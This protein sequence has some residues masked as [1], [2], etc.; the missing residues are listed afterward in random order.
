MRTFI[1]MDWSEIEK[2]IYIGEGGSE[3]KEKWRDK[4]RSK[5][6][7]TVQVEYLIRQSLIVMNGVKLM[8]VIIGICELFSDLSKKN[9]I[10]KHENEKENWTWLNVINE[11]WIWLIAIQVKLW[12][13]E[14]SQEVWGKKDLNS[15]MRARLARYPPCQ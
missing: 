13:D 4:K 12:K 9:N 7:I 10:E 15:V 6:G 14:Y 8:S 1:V 2:I 3:R 5:D 11:S